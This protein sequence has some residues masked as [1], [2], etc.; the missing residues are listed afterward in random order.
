MKRSV[1]EEA[2][3]SLGKA[4]KVIV[5]SKFPLDDINCDCQ[6]LSR[7]YARTLSSL[8]E[9]ERRI[10]LED[11]TPLQCPKASGK[12]LYN[13]ICHNCKEVIAQVNAENK[14]L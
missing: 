12:K 3:K 14:K 2:I 6:A 8:N 4:D 7:G 10:L 5:I 1:S 9:K 13:L 11:I